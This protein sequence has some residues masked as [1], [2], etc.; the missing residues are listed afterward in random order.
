[1]SIRLGAS[2][3]HDLAVIFVPRG[4]RIER[5]GSWVVWVGFV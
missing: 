2:V 4:A 3:C 1:M 5:E